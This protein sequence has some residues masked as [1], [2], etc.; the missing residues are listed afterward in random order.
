MSTRC[1]PVVL[2]T[3]AL[4]VA[5]G[6]KKKGEENGGGKPAPT[7]A[8]D[9][10]AAKP[11]KPAPPADKGGDNPFGVDLSGLA[12]KL[13][14]SWVV[15]GSSLGMKAAWKVEGDKVT[16]FEGGKEKTAELQIF[17]PCRLKVVEKSGGGTMSTSTNFAFDGD[18]LWLGLGSAGVKMGD[19]VFACVSADVY[20]LAGDKCVKWKQA[21]FDKWEQSEAEC[22]IG[23][24]GK[25]TA[26]GTTLEPAGNAFVNQQMKGNEAKK[27]D[28]YE[29]AKAA[30]AK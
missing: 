7:Q 13:Q 16:I 17:A 27:M 23:D 3:L 30:V 22:S 6:C 24:D 18:K 28:D 8:A 9:A 11:D 1:I 19:K 29:A 25:L 5:G 4:L 15:G 21:M 14:G 2:S 20:V 10:A 26:G 12:S